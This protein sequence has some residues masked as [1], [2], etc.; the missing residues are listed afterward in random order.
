[1]LDMQEVTGSIPV[2]P[3]IKNNDLRQQL[4]QITGTQAVICVIMC[5]TAPTWRELGFSILGMSD[6]TFPAPVVFA[7]V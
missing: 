6:R 3:T 7:V 2:S 5:Q 4:T 1:M